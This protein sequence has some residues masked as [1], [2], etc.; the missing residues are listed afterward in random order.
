VTDTASTLSATASSDA[1]GSKKM[2]PLT[3]IMR[4]VMGGF[5]EEVEVEV[6]FEVEFEEVEEEVEEG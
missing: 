1:E 3:A 6:G 5:A 4:R 2:F